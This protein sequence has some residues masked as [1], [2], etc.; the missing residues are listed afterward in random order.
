MELHKQ[1]DGPFCVCCWAKCQSLTE[2][3][4]SSHLPAQRLGPG[5]AELTQH[6][7][8]P[9]GAAPATGCPAPL[10]GPEG[11]CDGRDE[12][13]AQAREVSVPGLTHVPAAV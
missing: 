13:N 1:R 9:C 12:Q 3:R 2:R 11:T 7:P 6:P 8:P 5:G 4:V 10:R